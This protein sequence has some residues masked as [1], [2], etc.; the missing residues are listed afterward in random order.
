MKKILILLVGIV[1]LF[2]TAMGQGLAVSDVEFTSNPLKF[3]NKTVTINLVKLNLET[4]TP[5]SPVIVAPGGSPVVGPAV[6]PK[7]ISG[8]VTRCN[9][10]RGFR[11]IDIDF[12]ND[13]SF[14]ACFFMSEAMYVALPKGQPSLNMQ[15]TFR[16]DNNFGYVVNLYKLK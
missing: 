13:P 5:G 14:N 16:G 3:N 10:P 9:A 11:A 15:I 8:P 1:S 7:P 6:A 12:L 4:T 2:G